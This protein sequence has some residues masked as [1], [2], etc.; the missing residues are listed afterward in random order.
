[1]THLYLSVNELHQYSLTP[2]GILILCRPRATLR[3]AR[4][5]NFHFLDLDDSRPW[6]VKRPSSPTTLG[7]S[8]VSCIP[9]GVKNDWLEIRT[10]IEEEGT[11]P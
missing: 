5:Q 1:M 6:A 4:A 2:S 3:E 10:E 11:I 7:V 8:K 9:G